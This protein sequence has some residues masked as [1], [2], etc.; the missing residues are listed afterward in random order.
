[1]LWKGFSM[2]YFSAE[3]HTALTSR[4][5]S[6]LSGDTALQR[7]YNKLVDLHKAIH[8]KMRNHH[9]YVHPYSQQSNAVSFAS[10]AAPSETEVMTIGY[11]RSN[12]EASMVER[13]MGRQSQPDNRGELRCH[14]VIELRLTPQYVTVELVV[15]PDAWWDQQNLVGKLSLRKHRAAFH[16]LLENM[17][18]DYQLGFWAGTHLSDMHLNT[19]KVS[20]TR[21]LDEWMDTFEDGQDYFRLGFWYSLEDEQLNADNAAQELFERISELYSVYSFLAWTS[22]NNFTNVYQK[23]RPIP[24]YA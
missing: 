21:A 16:K 24:V 3:D 9:F 15:S 10:A 14:P 2:S 19:S 20:G 7:V 6:S 8:A 13:L 11:F 22:N 17:Q 18:G 4:E 1:M 23:K 12:L 5:A